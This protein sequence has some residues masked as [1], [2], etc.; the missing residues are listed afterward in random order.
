MR[1]NDIYGCYFNT[2]LEYTNY[3]SLCYRPNRLAVK[4]VK[5]MASSQGL[6]IG[7]LIGSYSRWVNRNDRALFY[8]S[9]MSL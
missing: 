9:V 8:V 4:K 7:N 3:S 2:T 5:C 6:P 1:R